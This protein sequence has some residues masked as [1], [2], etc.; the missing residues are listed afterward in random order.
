M[1]YNKYDISQSEHNQP[2]L[3]VQWSD[4]GFRGLERGGGGGRDEG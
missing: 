2:M 4:T 3:R 1:F